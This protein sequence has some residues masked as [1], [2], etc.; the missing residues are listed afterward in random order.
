MD[1]IKVAETTELE[2]GGKKMVT[3]KGVD[4]LITNIEGVYHAVDNRCPH[5]GGSLVEGVL[6]GTHITCPLHGSIFDVV[7]GEVVKPGKLLFM[8]V[9]VHDLRKYPLKIEGN[10]ILIAIP[11]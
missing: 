3:L 4:I 7:T 8:S 2:P 5:M 1:F 10:D 11:E 9:K 6:E